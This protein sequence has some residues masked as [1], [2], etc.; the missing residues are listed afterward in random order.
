VERLPERVRVEADE[1]GVGVVED[2]GVV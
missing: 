1:L 2:G